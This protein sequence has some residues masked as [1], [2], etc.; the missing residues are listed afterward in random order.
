MDYKE[1]ERSIIKKFRKEIWAKFVKAVNDYELIKEKLSKMPCKVAVI[2]DA[3]YLMTNTFMT[4][5]SNPK[6]GASTFDLFNT[7]GD[8]FWNLILFIK[9]QLPEDVRVYFMMHELSNDTGEVK[10]RTIGKL[11]DEKVCIE[12]MFTVCLHCMTNGQ[13]HYFKTQGGSNDIA[14]S[15]EDM[16]ELEIENDLKMVDNRIVEFYGFGG[17]Q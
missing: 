3:G 10:V 16:F 8:Q 5:H 9:Q 12:G 14:K 7:I 6:G 15:P 17:E 1:V 13:K 11:L 4:G 2:D